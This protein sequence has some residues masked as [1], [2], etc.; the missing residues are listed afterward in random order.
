M[1]DRQS[2]YKLPLFQQKLWSRV[3]K[4]DGCWNWTGAKLPLGYGYFY[5][6]S[7]R[8]YVHRATWEIFNKS[9]IP[10]GMIV[11]HKCD[12]PGCVRPEHLFLGTD[13]T[14]SD[15]KVAKGRHARGRALPRT[16]LTEEI[17]VEIRGRYLAGDV[18]QAQLSEKYGVSQG[19]IFRLLSGMCW[20]HVS[21]HLAE[22]SALIVH[23]TRRGADH[24]MAKLN[25][26]KV[27]EIRRRCATGE[28]AKSLAKEFGVSAAMIFLI[29]SNKNWTK[30]SSVRVEFA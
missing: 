5:W 19:S 29:K 3:Q 25:W 2:I 7:L 21:T 27:A 12:N 10:D 8:F 13:K 24:A 1:A 14:N 20:K 15:D 6:K 22:T 17:V 26:D 4:G 23:G 16:K 18:S 9:N 30:P 28:S 11:C